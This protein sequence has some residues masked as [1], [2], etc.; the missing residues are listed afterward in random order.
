MN[1]C[2]LQ[3]PIFTSLPPSLVPRYIYHLAELHKA[4]Q[5]WVEAANTLLLHA[6]LLQWSSTMQKHEGA[7]P[8][9]TSAER[10]EA[11]YDEIVTLFDKGKVGLGS[12]P[13]GGSVPYH[14]WFGS[15]L[16]CVSVPFCSC[17]SVVYSSVRP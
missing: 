7:F 11:L 9:Q 4:S 3:T 1:Q 5:N 14:V 2:H 8:R 10:K 12:I 13:A 6:E 17:G 15:V 16:S